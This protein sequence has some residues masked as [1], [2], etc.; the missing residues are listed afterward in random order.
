MVICV[1][2]IFT[3]NWVSFSL[4]YFCLFVL[5][6]GNT[7]LVR[8][9]SALLLQTCVNKNLYYCNFCIYSTVSF[10]FWETNFTSYFK[11]RNQILSTGLATKIKSMFH[12]STWPESSS[13]TVCLSIAHMSRN[14][15]HARTYTFQTAKPITDRRGGSCHLLV[16]FC[17]MGGL[18]Y[19]FWVVIDYH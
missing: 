19:V 13:H 4:M 15:W 10:S 5:T 11:S 8:L 18:Q 1:W 17:T 16:L 12:L 2:G 9:T 3:S 6:K 7:G 14:R